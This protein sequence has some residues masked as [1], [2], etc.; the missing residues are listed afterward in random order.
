[1][2]PAKQMRIMTPTP[3]KNKSLI[4]IGVYLMALELVVVVSAVLIDESGKVL[5]TQRPEGKFKS[6]FWEFP[7]GKLENGEKP[8]HALY[9]ELK[10]ELSI[11]VDL[12]SARPLTFMS[13]AYAD[14]DRHVLMPVYSIHQWRGKA[15]GQENQDIAWVTFDEIEEYNFLPANLEM[16]D[17]INKLI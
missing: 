12:T 17:R 4:C 9:R 14:I 10:E 15:T 3:A 7:G 5:I 13:H 8:E 2:H 11:K 6:G 1:M 16:L